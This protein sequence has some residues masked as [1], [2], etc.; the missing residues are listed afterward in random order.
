MPDMA[1]LRNQAFCYKIGRLA[2]RNVGKN[3]KFLR[4]VSILG[5]S[6]SNYKL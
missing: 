5:P 4:M 6:A 1:S 3:A 2:Q